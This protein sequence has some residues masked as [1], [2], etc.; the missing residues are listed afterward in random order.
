M[1]TSAERR[2][3]AIYDEGMRPQ[4][5][6]R[7]LL[8]D[9]LE[10]VI[11]ELGGI[12]DAGIAATFR[13]HTPRSLDDQASIRSY[14]V[15]LGT[16]CLE[17]SLETS[18]RPFGGGP[19]AVL[20]PASWEIDS[21]ERRF[22]LSAVDP[23]RWEQTDVPPTHWIFVSESSVDEW[24]QQW[25]RDESDEDDAVA[26]PFSVERRTASGEPAGDFGGSALLPI[27]EVAALTGMSRSTIY[28]RIGSGRFP[29]AVRLGT[30]MSRWRR[31]DV[32]AWL[33][34]H[35]TSN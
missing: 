18:V 19:T 21:F 23:K 30:R 16:Q 8:A 2:L 3:W 4:S 14:I 22:A 11:S 31:D 32:E 17:G 34:R 9:L 1:E 29:D 27:G 25:A 20:P 10:F 35:A 15:W 5:A 33:R 12:R 7:V 13:D 6:G 26:R 24:W 28:D